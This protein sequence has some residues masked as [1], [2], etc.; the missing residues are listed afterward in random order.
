MTSQTRI[1]L[2]LA[3]VVT[4]SAI[5]MVVSSRPQAS[6]AGPLG[7]VNVTCGPS[8]RAVV[9]QAATGASSAVVNV[10]CVDTAEAAVAQYAPMYGPAAPQ[11]APAAYTLPMA[12][13]PAAL[14]QAAVYQPQPVAARP[15]GQVPARRATSG[16]PSTQKRLLVIGGTAGAGA[17]IGALVGGRK[18]ALIGAAIGAGGATAV[19][20]LKNR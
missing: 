13:Q 1:G 6:A 11:M 19:D 18:G 3:L 4:A 9:E 8:Q 16:K 7:N 12:V 17:G 15:A 10:S 5:A 14:P 2:I 20:Q